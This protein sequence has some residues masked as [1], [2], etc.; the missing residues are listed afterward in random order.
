VTGA[1]VHRKWM[2]A[3]RGLVVPSKGKNYAAQKSDP[4]VPFG[5]QNKTFTAS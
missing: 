5:S 2:L 3:S 4:L 1:T